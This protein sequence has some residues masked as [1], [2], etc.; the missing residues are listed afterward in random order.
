MKIRWQILLLGLWLQSGLA[1]ELTIDITQGVTGAIPAAVAAFAVTGNPPE[2]VSGI[3]NA[4]LGRSG[5][6]DL[7][8][9][10][11]HPERPSTAAQI[12]SDKWRAL[13]TDYLVVGEV[14]AV[15]NQFEVQF[16]LF[17]LLQKRVILDQTFEVAPRDL[18]RLAH[19]ISD[20]IYARLTG[21]A[22]AFDTRIA[23]VTVQGTGA[24]R[25]HILAVAD[26]DGANPRAVLR[27][28]QPILSPS[29][30]PDG[31]RLAYVSFENRRPQVVIQD[32]ASGRR[33]VATAL[34]GINGAPSWSPDG[35]RLVV[36]L[37]KDGNPE[38]YVYRLGGGL[39][40]LTNHPA[41]DTEPVFTPDGNSV[42]FTSDRGGSPQLYRVSA[43]G[44]E[45]TRLTFEGNY[46]AR[47]NVSPDGRYV[48]FVHRGN[49]G[50]S[51][52]VMELAT[53]RMRVL[54]NGPLDESPSFAPNSQIVLYAN[55]RGR[56]GVVSVD[57][58]VRQSLVVQGDDV[59][60]PAWVKNLR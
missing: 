16:Q 28:G 3:V 10:S 48:A 56:L 6:I 60:E 50:F 18:R 43:N 15:G 27:S 23:Y 44:G 42:I 21:E 49:R 30:S 55:G 24:N 46:N 35:A 41:I 5:R 26:V 19:R 31:R 17:D 14:K 33:Q 36:T 7:L 51:I 52:A 57:G 20:A 29:W 54:T 9:P 22:G 25:R 4:N 1:Q 53:R 37:S 2:D 40:R 58:R 38:I 39:V 8:A 32:L 47:A 59:R 13:N 45:P 11:R 34:P 12:T